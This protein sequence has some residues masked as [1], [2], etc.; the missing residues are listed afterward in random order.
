MC[1]SNT[2]FTFLRD[3]DD[4]LETERSARGEVSGRD[5]YQRLTHP[6]PPPLPRRL[7]HPAPPPFTHPPPPPPNRLIHP[8][9][10]PPRRLIQPAFALNYPTSLTVLV[11]NHAKGFDVDVLAWRDNPLDRQTGNVRKIEHER[12]TDARW[13]ASR[14]CRGHRAQR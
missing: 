9:P 2:Y 6:P 3:A 13:R 5:A 8:P 14:Y 11:F 12:T 10:P 4:S 7:I 1:R